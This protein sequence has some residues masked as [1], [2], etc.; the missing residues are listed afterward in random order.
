MLAAER[1]RAGARYVLNGATIT[2]S[3]ALALDRSSSPA[4]AGRLRIVP[5]GGGALRR[6]AGSKPSTRFA[7]RTPSLCRARI[8]TF[9]HGH[10][11]D[12]TLATRELGVAYTPVRETFRRTI[13]WAVG[14][15]LV[16]R[17]LL[18]PVE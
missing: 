18:L 10:R 15:G 5:A 6:G 3:E 17:E 7:A 12:G 1:G 9:L 4:C 16:E 8:R 14:E 11:Y 2:S 13:E